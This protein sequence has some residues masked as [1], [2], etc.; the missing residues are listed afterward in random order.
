MFLNSTNSKNNLSKLNDS[1]KKLN[2]GLTLIER[3]NEERNRRFEK[4]LNAEINSRYYFFQILK[5]IFKIINFQEIK[6]CRF[7]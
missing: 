1:L 5:F 2:E 4:V 7:K 6:R 3:Q